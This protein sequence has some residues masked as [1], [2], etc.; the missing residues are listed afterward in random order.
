MQML[1][2]DYDWVRRRLTPHPLGFYMTALMLQNPAGDGLPRIYVHCAQ[3]SN[4]VIESSRQLVRSWPGW[5]WVD[6]SALH[7]ATITHPDKVA[8]A[9]LD[10]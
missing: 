10:A 7:D 3:P 2:A 5:S 9:L 8:K 6:L 4:P 1:S